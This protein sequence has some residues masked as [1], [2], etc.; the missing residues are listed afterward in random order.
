MCPSV[1]VC[2]VHVQTLID[3]A[4]SFVEMGHFPRR[5]HAQEGIPDWGLWASKAADPPF[6]LLFRSLG[7][8]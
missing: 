5:L 4:F 3:G 8:N 6:P 7:S 1:N 2:Y